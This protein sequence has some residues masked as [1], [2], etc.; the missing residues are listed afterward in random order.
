MEELRCLC[1]R[2]LNRLDLGEMILV[3]RQSAELA[4]IALEAEYLEE[5]LATLEF[6]RVLGL[7]DGERL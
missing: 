2:L 4:L 7:K 1:G 5:E 3:R 6:R